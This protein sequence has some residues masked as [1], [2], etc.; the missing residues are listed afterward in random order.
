MKAAT[1]TGGRVR[2]SRWGA[3][4]F[5]MPRLEDGSPD[6]YAQP[7]KPDPPGESRGKCA[8]WTGERQ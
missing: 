5:A 4:A 7:P 2:Q 1:A 8:S 3:A 6:A